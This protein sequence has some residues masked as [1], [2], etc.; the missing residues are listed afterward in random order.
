MISRF[1]LLISRIFHKTCPDPFVIAILLT[2]LT[3]VL[4][5]W[6][7]EFPAAVVSLHDR[8]H[9]LLDAWRG[10]AGIWR[11]LGFG[12]QMCL[13][14]VTGHALAA[15]RPVRAM[16]N[17]LA[18]V[19]RS[20]TS[21]AVMVSFIAC[22][23]GLINWGLGLIVGALLARDV[24][25]SLARRGVTFHYPLLAAAGYMGLI[26]FHGG[27]S[28][29]APL[30]ATTRAAASRVLPESALVFLGDGVSLDRTLLSPLNLFVTGGMLLLI[31]LLFWLL[32][33]SRPEDCPPASS[34]QALRSEAIRPVE[35]GAPGD[36]ASSTGAIPDWLD[37]SPLIVWLLA[38]LLALGLFQYA[39]TRGLLNIQINEI[40]AA[41]FAL[42]LVLHGSPR[43]YMRAIEDGARDCAGV[44]IQFP[45]YAG[46]IGLMNASGL[47]GR[48]AHAFTDIATPQTTPLLSF[49]A[50]LVVGIFVPS[51]GGQ[52]GL[53]GPIALQT[54]A[55]MNVDTG[56]MIMTIAY[57]DEL[58]NMLQPFWAL[59][60]LSIT[61]VRARDIVGYTTIVM[62]A[63]AAW[64]ALGLLLF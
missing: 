27:L 39:Q 59:P 8:A 54:G 6:W 29:S 5:L 43:A 33:P 60:L 21:A 30:T 38:I 3:A 16:I 50:A 12:M 37:R 52:W 23:T 62:L 64:V 10:D 51:G 47:V 11:L 41:M 2:L 24:G 55:Q 28:G 19:P 34:F 58:A 49:L 32:T 26:I 35:A 56:T 63:A 22:L 7:G 4:A 44:I 53:Q 9:T 36:A 48:I 1:G 13:I 14:L 15:T 61:G 45:I 57:G 31:P 46:I 40:N 20:A 25:R 17:A 18:D 42:G